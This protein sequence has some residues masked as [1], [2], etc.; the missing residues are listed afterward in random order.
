MLEVFLNLNKNGF[1]SM[2]TTF[3]FEDHLEPSGFLKI[4]PGHII[5]VSFKSRRGPF[6]SDYDFKTNIFN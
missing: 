3:S 2:T 5:R 6:K 4:S 1:S